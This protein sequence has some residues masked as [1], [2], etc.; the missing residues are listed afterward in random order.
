MRKQLAA[1]KQGPVQILLLAVLI[2]AGCAQAGGKPAE[3]E[4]GPTD[5]MELRY[6]DQFT[7]EYDAAGCALVTIGD[8]DRFLLVPDGT[9]APEDSSM[10]V[11]RTP[12]KKLYVASS[13]VMDPLS[14]LDALDA[15]RLTGTKQEDWTLPA[16]RS[17]MEA[18]ELLYAGK[19]AA[20][21]YE[22]LL[23]EGTDLAVENTMIFHSPETKEQL[24]ALGIPVLTERSS[25]ESH[26]LGRLEWI[27]L[28]GL[29]TGR[30]AEAE[31]FFNEQAALAEQVFVQENTGKTASFFYISA[32]GSIIVR[33][34]GDYIAKMI[35]LAGGEYLP[36]DL[37][38]GEA[39]ARSTMNMQA[40]SFY[41][42]AK[43]ADVL[44][45]N[46]TIGGGL[47]SLEG[48]LAKGE[49]LSDFRA[50]RNGDVWCTEADMF[51]QSSGIAGMIDEF[52]RI[53]SGTA[54]EESLQYFHRLI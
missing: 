31:V 34:P 8:T 43:E 49:W 11:L 13:S 50:V 32:N 14:R 40:E 23:S 39:D 22:L 9:E 36:S 38:D 29:L 27:K 7:V 33:R 47:D 21:D 44:F 1:G 6:A 10:T 53:L 2:L 41:L 20:P 42:A 52:R 26:P 24:E 15:V 5:R 12:L 30:M 28:F 17:R 19:Y 46:A 25:Y 51:Q 54:D 18:G 4:P 16:V 3:T 48:L 35:G 37:Q 45:Y